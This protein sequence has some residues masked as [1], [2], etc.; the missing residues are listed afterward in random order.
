[1]YIP[2]GASICMWACV[3]LQSDFIQFSFIEQ[4]LYTLIWK[5]FIILYQKTTCINA[6]FLEYLHI[7]AIRTQHLYTKAQR[8]Q[9]AITTPRKPRCGGPALPSPRL[10]SYSNSGGL[11]LCTNRHR[12]PGTDTKTD[13]C[14]FNHERWPCGWTA[15]SMPLGKPVLQVR[16]NLGPCF[17]P[18][19]RPIKA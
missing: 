8:P 9:T 3:I 7:Q 5:Y 19:T 18:L 11:C 17:I 2:R 12:E 6:Q 15:P 10:Y 1:M 16:R 13:R 14:H 4:F